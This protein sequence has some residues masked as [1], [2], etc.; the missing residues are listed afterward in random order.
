MYSYSRFRSWGNS[1]I[2]FKLISQLLVLYFYAFF[3]SYTALPPSIILIL[4][5]SPSN[6]PLPSL[7]DSKKELSS[8]LSYSH[9]LFSFPS[10]LPYLHKALNTTYLKLFPL[11]SSSTFSIFPTPLI[12][13]TSM[14]PL[15]IIPIPY[16]SFILLSSP[17]FSP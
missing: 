1:N 14:S 17:S 7:P 6:T 2:L 10:P 11:T 5:S 9:I 13:P 8:W 4:L 16:P 15:P 12:T 3:F